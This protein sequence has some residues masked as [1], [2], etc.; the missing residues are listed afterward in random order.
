MRSCSCPGTPGRRGLLV[1]CHLAQA[2]VC[3]LTLQHGLPWTP[4]LDGHIC[5]GGG[6]LPG[7]GKPILM[8]AGNPDGGGRRADGQRVVLACRLAHRCPGLAGLLS[9][10]VRTEQARAWPPEDG[11][12]SPA[13]I[14]AWAGLRGAEGVAQTG[15][16]D[17]AEF[18]R[19]EGEVLA[20]LPHGRRV[21]AQ[22]RGACPAGTARSGRPSCR[23][24][25]TTGSPPGSASWE[26]PGFPQTTAMNTRPAMAARVSATCRD[27][28]RYCHQELARLH[29]YAVAAGVPTPAQNASTGRSRARNRRSSPP[30]TVPK[31]ALNINRPLTS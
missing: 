21:L 20:Q 28:P 17:R 23:S 18:G 5:R 27:V 9:G 26:R 14:A 16:H 22:P 13:L 2:K 8:D 15:G 12:Q 30:V 25:A 1:P 29:P 6:V 24:G 19:R 7:H 11:S 4:G 10:A 31:A 3:Q